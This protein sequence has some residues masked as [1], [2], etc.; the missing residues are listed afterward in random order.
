MN[1][2]QFP[3]P[4]FDIASSREQL[5]ARRRVVL[6]D[7]MNAEVAS[8]LYDELTHS[9]EWELS[10]TTSTGPAAIDAKTLAQASEQEKNHL[11]EQILHQASTRFSYCYGRYELIPGNP[12]HLLT[13]K[14]Y[15]ASHAFIEFMR[16]LTGD[17]EI[18][19]A[20]AHA[21]MYSAGYFLK[22]HDDIYA[23][24]NRRFAYVFGFTRD[25]HADW[26]GMLCFLDKN[27]EVED[28]FV[29]S[30]NTLTVFNVPQDHFVSLVSPFAN[31]ERLAITGWLF[32]ED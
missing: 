14:N 29:P 31:S 5:S 20:D 19:R 12:E 4:D 13:A 2:N 18:V 8:N 11:Q 7:V 23:G 22:K 1:S 21:T 30:F 32:A 17:Q 3:N 28:V 15:L 10:L 24:K 25:W 9:L 26:G 16:D 27:G 6:K